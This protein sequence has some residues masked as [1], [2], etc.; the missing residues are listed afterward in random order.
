MSDALTPGEEM[1]MRQ[2]FRATM[3]RAAAIL[4]RLTNDDVKDMQIAL[5]ATGCTVL[6]VT[7]VDRCMVGAAHLRACAENLANDEVKRATSMIDKMRQEVR[8]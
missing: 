7:K 4:E 6:Q 8:S 3:L 2:S 1:V 5:L